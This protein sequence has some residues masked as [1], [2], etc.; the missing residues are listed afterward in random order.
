MNAIG[1]VLLVSILI[2]AGYYLLLFGLQ[3]RMLFPAPRGPAR[4]ALPADARHTSLDAAGARVDAWFLP[5]L[6]P[7]D[8]HPALILA[9]GNAERA[10]DWAVPVQDLRRAGI[11]VLLPEFPGYGTSEGSPSQASLTAAAL[12]AYDWLRA[13][14]SVDSG[15]IIA[16][17]RSIGGGVATRLATRRPVAALVLESSITSLRAFAR[18]FLAPGA[19]VRDPFDNLAELRGYHGPLLVLHGERDE[20]A[21]FA[22]GRALAAAVAGAEFVPMPCGHNDCDRPWPRVLE[23]LA[24]H[25]VLEGPP[26]G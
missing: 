7:G 2:A 22:H 19:L 10:E 17:G 8:R 5:A 12:A 13:Q 26:P 15:R 9:H 23:F 14:P 11:A 24:R 16:H 25:Q 20:V 3:R 18:R 6:T 1:R 21:P 4:T